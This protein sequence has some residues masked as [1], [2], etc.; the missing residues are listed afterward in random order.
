MTPGSEAR[1]RSG[2]GRGVTKMTWAPPARNERV[3][4]ASTA[5]RPDRAGAGHDEGWRAVGQ[6]RAEGGELVAADAGQAPQ[7]RPVSRRAHLPGLGEGDPGR[8]QVDAERAPRAGHGGVQ[9]GGPAGDLAQRGG[10]GLAGGA[11]GEQGDLGLGAGAGGEGPAGR[12]AGGQVAGAQPGQGVVVLLCQLEDQL[13]LAQRGDPAGQQGPVTGHD[14]VDPGAGA[15]GQDPGDHVSQGAAAGLAEGGG[16]PFP[17]VQQHQDV[18]QPI[19]GRDGGALFGDPGEAA[20]REL[21]LPAGEFGAEAGE[22]AGGA[23]VLGAGDHRAAM[24]KASQRQQRPVAAVDAVQVGVG[25]AEPD[26]DRGGDGAQQLGA[27]GP[28]RAGRRSGGRRC[29]G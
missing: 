28:R 23:L 10:L 29:P 19:G 1:E 12:D 6:V 7:R 14:Q 27:P 16:E 21:V 15:L 25:A 17:P 2:E 24:G 26:G 18:R 22:Q 3:I 8:E 11:G 4:A 20:G 9:G 13:V 5:E